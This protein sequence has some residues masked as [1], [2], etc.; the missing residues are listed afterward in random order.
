MAKTTIAGGSNQAGPLTLGV[1][2]WDLYSTLIEQAAYVSYYK[3][4]PPVACPRCGEP[5]R[6]GP[7]QDPAVLYCKFDGWQ[8]PRDYDPETQA[9]M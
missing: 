3:S 8:F 2:G 7:P 6:Q 4:Q 5:L 9:G 1:L